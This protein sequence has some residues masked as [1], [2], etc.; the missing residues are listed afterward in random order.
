MTQDPEQSS[1]TESSDL[2]IQ[3]W[4]LLS[5]APAMVFALIAFADRSV[6]KAESRT[7][8]EQWAERMSGIRLNDDETDQQLFQWGMGEA[9]FGVESLLKTPSADLLHRVENAFTLMQSTFELE[10]VDSYRTEL[11]AFAEEIAAASGDWLGLRSPVRESEENMLRRVRHAMRG[12]P[13]IK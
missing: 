12:R 6:S 5:S 2:T 1:P 7:F 3:Q 8:F 4:E 13:I 11:F 10:R 9:E